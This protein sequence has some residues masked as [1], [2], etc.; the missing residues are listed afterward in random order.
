MARFVKKVPGSIVALIAGTI[1]V[2]AFGW[3]VET[4]GTRFGGIPAGLPPL[5]IPTFHPELIGGLIMP[6]VTVAM[7]GAIESLMSAVVADRMSGDRHNSNMELVAQGLANIAS[8]LVGGLPATGAIARTATNIRSGALTPV[9]GLVHA[10]TLLL[11]LLF[12]A[13]LARHIPLAVLA[14]ILMVVAY[15]MGEWAEIP[16]LIR[17]TKT[18]VAV[19]IV[20][21]TLTVF[22]DLTVAVGVGMVLAALLFIH[23]VAETT[24]VTAVTDEYVREGHAHI[25]Q[26]KAIPAYVSI[27]R[28]HGPFLFGATDKLRVVTDHVDGLPEIVILRLRNMTA[29]DGTGLHAIEQL[30]ATLHASGRHL[31]LCGARRQ[32]AAVMAR[33]GFQDHVGAGNVCAHVEDAL[34]RAHDLHALAHREVG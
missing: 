26:N 31:L 13:P 18:D 3:N 27:F 9:A 1:A 11:I 15:N 23:R 20:T 8:P 24:T 2:A 28:I 14:A 29:L 6:A 19:W 16:D 4:I 12:A 10:A 5:R 32:P 22:A 30:A 17:L 25:L 33:A 34:R 21:L 7:L